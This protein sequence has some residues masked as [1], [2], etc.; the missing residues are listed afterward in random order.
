MPI[1]EVLMRDSCGKSRSKIKKYFYYNEYDSDNFPYISDFEELT[2]LD[3][4]EGSK[5]FSDVI[6]LFIPSFILIIVGLG[7]IG[8]WISICVCSIKPKCFCKKDNKNTNRTRFICLMVFFGFALSIIV[9]AIV[10]I[11]Y[12]AN[13][14]YDFN[15]TICSLLMFQY[16]II[17]GQGLLAK[18]PMYKPYWY[19]SNGINEAVS[20]INSFL[21]ELKTTCEENI[22][23]FES[24]TTDAVT[25][26]LSLTIYL[27]LIYETNKNEKI[28]A[29]GPKEEDVETIPIYIN[30][31]GPT[32]TN[33][34]YTGKVIEDY[35]KNFEYIIYDI[36]FP[37]T[38]L[39]TVL[40]GDGGQY[41]TN[42]LEGFESVI[43]N[44]NTMLDNLSSKITEYITD[45][46]SLIVNLG[47]KFNLALFIIVIIIII[48]Q[49]ILYIMYYFHPFTLTKYA[50]YV[51]IHILNFILILCFI[52]N[53]IFSI[54]AMVMGNMADIVDAVL[55]KE[56]LS[57]QTPR[58]IDADG[59][60]NK[61]TR[62]LRGDGDLFE[63][64][65]T[66]DV[67][68]IVDPLTQLYGLYTPVKEV[69]SRINNNT[70]NNEYNSL[71]ALD[72][73]IEELEKMKEDFVLTTTKEISSNYDITTMLD[74]LNKYTMAGRRYQQQCITATYDIWTTNEEHCTNVQADIN[75]VT[76]Q[77]KYLKNYDKDPP[78]AT[79]A[80]AA[81][82]LYKSACSLINTNDFPDVK[83]A[84]YN[85]ILFFSKYRKANQ[86]L[87]DKIL[88]DQSNPSDP[89]N[90]IIPGFKS[91]KNNFKANFID[92]VKTVMPIIDEK[93]TGKVHT[94][95]SNLLNDTVQDTRKLSEDFNLFSWMNCTSIGQDY[96]ATLSTLKSNLTGEMRVITYCSLVCEI[97]IIAVLYIMLGL[98][99]NLRDKIFE[100]NDERNVSHSSDNVEEI[101]IDS[102]TNRK[103][104]EKNSDEVYAVKNKKNFQVVK[105][106]DK[107]KGIDVKSKSNLD[108]EGKGIEHPVMV[109]INGPSGKPLF[110]NGE[111]GEM[112]HNQMNKSKN[113]YKNNKETEEELTS[114]EGEKKSKS[115]SKSKS[116]GKTTTNGENEEGEEEDDDEEGEEEEDG[117]TNKKS[118][119]KS[120]NTKSKG[121]VSSDN[122]K[123]GNTNDKKKE[124]SE[125]SDTVSFG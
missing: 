85:Y 35:E 2:L 119:S 118:K 45:Y 107:R 79:G 106:I 56:N 94:L 48:V 43:G 113:Y 84:V 67:K 103:S 100:I 114:S 71:I 124:T 108:E 42:G 14:E 18:K 28:E 109:S 58:L 47:Y 53:G 69:N 65:V 22:N 97:L 40:S 76:G 16:Q 4:I 29:T 73:F 90:P 25:A 31:L 75:I 102:D 110:A 49:V 83:T 122:K 82:D 120:K 30:N 27:E 33:E 121:K 57:S 3:L 12:I 93:I 98:N 111:N 38:G 51:F 55:S 70:G 19:G 86:D 32:T 36:L 92:K 7:C 26:G 72:N 63:E 68:T 20:N 77:C 64:F 96:N 74:E 88:E 99:K 41:L 112:A 87:I 6:P 115:K 78:D 37:V 105:D 5:S 21:Q 104:S 54:L 89:D 81:R 44:L 125:G 52:Y 9:L 117:T 23:T 80:E 59:D 91:L 46:S 62:C 60:L 11:V 101:E 50:L 34:S 123:T 66:D 1:D 95:F 39:C 116:K 61:L 15:G 24:T 17:N 10:L 13:A 8:V